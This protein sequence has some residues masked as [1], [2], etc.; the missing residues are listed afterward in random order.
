[1]ANAPVSNFRSRAWM[2]APGG[3]APITAATGPHMFN[4][5][6]VGEVVSYRAMM[7]TC[8]LD[9]CRV[10]VLVGE[11]ATV[12]P[13]VWVAFV[14]YDA[15]G[16]A[17]MEELKSLSTCEQ[18]LPVSSNHIGPRFAYPPPRSSLWPE[19]GRTISP[20]EPGDP[21]PKVA[22]GVEFRSIPGVTAAA[23]EVCRLSFDFN[24]TTAR[25]PRPQPGPHV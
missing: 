25:D 22:W 19:F 17:T 13:I 24:L 18:L 4:P 2:H 7:G 6:V 23:G 21:A 20:L 3:T 11:N 14:R 1:M 5:H 12:L 16:P 10:S 9:S 8:M 15:T